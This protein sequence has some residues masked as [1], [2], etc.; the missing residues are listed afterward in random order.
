MDLINL[1]YRPHFK[2]QREIKR[3]LVSY[4][5]GRVSEIVLP[6]EN[7]EDGYIAKS[8][9]M[10]IS[11]NPSKPEE[12]EAIALLSQVKKGFRN[13]FIK[14]IF[15]IS[16]PSIPL[17]SFMNDSGFRM[18]RVSIF[19]TPEG[20]APSTPVKAPDTPKTDFVAQP[21]TNIPAIKNTPEISDTEL[22]E[23]IQQEPA[24]IAEE[25]DRANDIDN[26]TNAEIDYNDLFAQMSGLNH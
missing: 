6:D 16:L 14:T 1:Y 11:L 15:R 17:T 2:F 8:I 10:H 12:A 19:D 21:Q 22:T 23:D 7:P 5:S 9:L 18:K 25:V 20:R 26:S 24:L 3:A 13:A 4:A